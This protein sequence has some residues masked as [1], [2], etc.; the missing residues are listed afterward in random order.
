MSAHHLLLR[1]QRRIWNTPIATIAAT[2]N[3][4]T[5]T[6]SSITTRIAT[7]AA[8]SP[9]KK[10]THGL[11]VF[12]VASVLVQQEGLT[13]RVGVQARTVEPAWAKYARQNARMLSWTVVGI[14]R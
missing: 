9:A 4:A 12:R 8:T 14:C 11:F 6:S 2:R 1:H 13:S 5:G 3:G 7:A 10:R